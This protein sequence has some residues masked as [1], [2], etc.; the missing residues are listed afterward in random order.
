MT[1]YVKPAWDRSKPP[2]QC[3]ACGSDNIRTTHKHGVVWRLYCKDCGHWDEEWLDRDST[4]R[5][6]IHG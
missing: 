4:K 6:N 3:P 5:Q 1:E 2:L